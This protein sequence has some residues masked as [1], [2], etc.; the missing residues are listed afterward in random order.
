MIILFL[1]MRRLIIVGVI[2][3]I[4]KKF[5]FPKPHKYKPVLKDVLINCP[6]SEGLQY[7]QTKIDLFKLIPQDGC[8][9]NLP[10][11]LQKQYIDNSF[12]PVVEKKI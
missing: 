9:I 12:I 2:K 1:K 10:E 7:N 8:W 4:S 5:N 3:T 11:D 6:S